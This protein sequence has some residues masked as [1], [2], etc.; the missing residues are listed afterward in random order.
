MNFGSVKSDPWPKILDLL[1]RTGKTYEPGSQIPLGFREG[2]TIKVLELDERSAIVAWYDPTRCRYDEQR[3]IRIKARDAGV[4][5]ITGA[6]IAIGAD[7]FRPA[8]T[9]RRIA[10]NAGEM[11]LTPAL[12][13]AIANTAGSDARTMRQHGR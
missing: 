3:W 10:A 5:A 12:Q 8:R 9:R 4:C 6:Q 2:V 1:K 7:V 13:C 11:I